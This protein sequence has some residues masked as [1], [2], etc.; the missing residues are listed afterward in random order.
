MEK[1]ALPY[2]YKTCDS[3]TWSCENLLMLRFPLSS[4]FQCTAQLDGV[5]GKKNTPSNESL[6]RRPVSDLLQVHHHLLAIV[7]MPGRLFGVDLVKEL[8]LQP[9]L[10]AP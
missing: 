1:G 8:P 5:F 10:G 4:P 9:L 6:M 2:R 3:A 7:Q